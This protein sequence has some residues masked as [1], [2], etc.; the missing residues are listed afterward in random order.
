MKKVKVW[1]GIDG[2]YCAFHE[3]TIRVVYDIT[4][5]ISLDD[6]MSLEELEAWDQDEHE[7]GDYE[8]FDAIL[9][10]GKYYINL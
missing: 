6:Y 9:D 7:Y 2:D 10:N 4:N 8:I 5:D 3:T 1:V